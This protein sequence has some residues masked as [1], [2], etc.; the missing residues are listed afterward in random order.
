MTAP[1]PPP[2]P[3]GQN[4]SQDGGQEGRRIR[5]LA[6]DDQRVVREGLAMLLSLLPDVEVVGTAADGEEAVRLAIATQPDVV[7]MD[8]R[9]PHL[10]GAAATRQLR[11][12][13]PDVRVIVLTTYADDRSVIDALRAGARGYLTKDAGAEEIRRA[14]HDVTSGRAVI[15]PAVQGHL[16]DAIAAPGEA[17]TAPA[18]PTA[19][20]G[21]IPAGTAPAG[22]A[23]AGTAPAGFV[24]AGFVP[25]GPGALTSPATDPI[26]D[27]QVLA[28]NLGLTPR[29][30]E[31]LA[32]I[33]EGL[34]N[35]EIAARLVVSE[36]TVKSHVNHLL[37][38][39]GVRGR[40]QAVSVAYQHG[41]TPPGRPR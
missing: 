30:G 9:M 34:S 7:L 28:A 12:R 5:V 20:A 16:V 1:A 35:L 37:A 17:P 6:A 31:V 19:R 15:D 25:A 36:A 13:C 29:E 32:L 2:G 24:P 26:P 11:E 14:L 41:L 21:T 39:M 27:P 22:T 38:K 8:L 18:A 10:D 40:A 23:P 3:A 33:A 4:G